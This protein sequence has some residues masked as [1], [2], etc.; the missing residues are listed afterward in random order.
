LKA[1][2]RFL[3]EKLTLPGGLLLE[4]HTARTEHYARPGALPEVE[5]SSVTDDL[6]RRDFTIN[7]MAV[8]LMPERFGELLD[9]F[10]GRRDLE[11]RRVRVLH[12]LSFVDDP[13][14]L[15]RAV[16]FEERFHF[17]MD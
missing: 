16:R 7:A 13:T 3:G 9:P 8:S 14:R 17:R 4:I 12:P 6:R 5:P 10:S 2:P 15:F 11:E 1:E